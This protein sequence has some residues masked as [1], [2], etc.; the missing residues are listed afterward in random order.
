MAKRYDC[1]LLLASVLYQKFEV[2]I[3]NVPHI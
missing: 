3:F 2:E 1:S